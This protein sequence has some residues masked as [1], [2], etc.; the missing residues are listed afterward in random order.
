MSAFGLSK[1]VRADG[2]VQNLLDKFRSNGTKLREAQRDLEQLEP[3]ITGAHPAR[4]TAASQAT[5]YGVGVAQELLPESPV[6]TGGLA[7]FALALLALGGAMSRPDVVAAGNGAL[8]PLTAELGRASVRRAR[9]YLSGE[10]PAP[11]ASATAPVE[12]GA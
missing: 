3:V 10:A 2:G 1:S 9:S 5:A 4:I 11:A 7:G 8:A 6:T 12:N